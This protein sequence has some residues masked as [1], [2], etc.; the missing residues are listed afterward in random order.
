[1]EYIFGDRYMVWPVKDSDAG[2]NLYVAML[3]IQGVQMSDGGN[4]T[5]Y[6]LLVHQ[7]DGRGNVIDTA[8]HNFM[9]RVSEDPNAAPVDSRDVQARLYFFR[10]MAR[11]PHFDNVTR[12]H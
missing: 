7:N 6:A 11:V 8:E 1:M 4:E 3:S 10:D 2:N 9:L 5:S 12:R